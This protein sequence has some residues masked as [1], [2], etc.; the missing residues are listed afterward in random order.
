MSG[1]DD[2]TDLVVIPPG[3]LVVDIIDK[4][5]LGP[6]CCLRHIR[7]TDLDTIT[8]L[9]NDKDVSAYTSD[10]IPHP[11]TRAD[12][13]ATYTLFTTAN[14][15]EAIYRVVAVDDIPVGCVIL[16]R[17]TADRRH[18]AEIGYWLGRRYWGAGVCC[19]IMR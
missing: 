10:R 8:Y 11:Y 5:S 15:Q 19:S 17:G 18:I 14:A 13:D 1:S 6:R 7:E 12:A 16:R 2:S 9:L 3:V 4:E